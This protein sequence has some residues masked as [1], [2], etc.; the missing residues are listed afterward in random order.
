MRD[1]VKKFWQ[2]LP[3]R[4]V[5]GVNLLTI[6]EI[7]F[8]LAILP[9]CYWA[10]PNWFV[11]NG[12]VETFQLIW[13]IGTLFLAL[14]AKNDKSLFVFTALVVVLLIMRETNLGRHYFCEK[15]LNPTD[16]CR[17]K[18]MKYG[19]FVEPLRDLFWAYVFYYAYKHKLWKTVIEYILQAPVYVWDILLMLIGAFL[20]TISECRLLDNEIL[21]ECGEL[22]CYLAFANCIWRYGYLQSAESTL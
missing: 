8:L 17:W 6:A 2:T 16:L 22:L 11:E 9:L 5:F 15:Y 7:C 19:I 18:S 12:V 14:G 20:G 13:L 10:N 3:Q 4:L 21:E 1:I